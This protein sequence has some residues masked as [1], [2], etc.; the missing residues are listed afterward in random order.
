MVGA[1]ASAP[2]REPWWPVVVS[3]LLFLLSPSILEE[4]QPNLTSR[5]LSAALLLVGGLLLARGVSLLARRALVR[6]GTPHLLPALRLVHLLMLVAVTLVALGAG[7]F[8]LT[9]LLAGGTVLTVV[10]GL[11]AQSLLANVMSGMVLTSSRAFSVG[12][13]VT[14]RS[15]AFGGIEYGGEVRDL[16]L[17]HTVLSG[18][19]GVIKVPN[20]RFL[21]ATLIVHPG[22]SQGVTVKLPPGVSLADAGA[23][24]GPDDRL[25]PV[26]L[27]EAGWETVIYV[28]PDDAGRAVLADLAR[29]VNAHTATPPGSTAS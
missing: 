3:G 8:R 20:A 29:L 12:D 23:V 10:L 2:A 14:V 22:G 9:G 5:R 4:L 18:A 7:G 1:V 6:A 25:V 15:W 16:T 19:A 24:L 26:A 17:T 21:D 11:A 13:R 27:S 28:A